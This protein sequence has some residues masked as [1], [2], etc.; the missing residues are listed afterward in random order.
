MH[1]PIHA[2]RHAGELKLYYL[3]EYPLALPM[4]NSTSDATLYSWPSLVTELRTAMTHNIT[5]NPTSNPAP[6]VN[7]TTITENPFARALAEGLQTPTPVSTFRRIRAGARP[8]SV[9]TAVQLFHYWSN[10]GLGEWNTTQIEEMNSQLQALGAMTSETDE[11]LHFDNMTAEQRRQAW[12]ILHGRP[13]QAI[14]APARPR[15]ERV[16]TDSDLLDAWI[17]YPLNPSQNQRLEALGAQSSSSLGW[18]QHFNDLNAEQRRQAMAIIRETEQHTAPTQAHTPSLHA[19][20]EFWRRTEFESGTPHPTTEPVISIGNPTDFHGLKH[21]EVNYNSPEENIWLGYYYTQNGYLV[22]MTLINHGNLTLYMS[23]ELATPEEREILRGVVTPGTG[24]RTEIYTDYHEFTRKQEELEAE[25]GVG[26]NIHESHPVHLTGELPSP[27]LQRM[28][29]MAYSPTAHEVTQ[30]YIH[31]EIPA[32]IRTQLRNNL[33]DVGAASEHDVERW[34]PDQRRIAWDIMHRTPTTPEP[35]P[36]PVPS[37]AEV[38]HWYYLH[39]I[40]SSG[41]NDAQAAEL[42]ALGFSVVGGSNHRHYLQTTIMDMSP[43]ELQQV[44]AVFHNQFTQPENE[45]P[46]PNPTAEAVLD[47]YGRSPP[48]TDEQMD[49]LENS[50]IEVDRRRREL[51]S[52]IREMTPTQLADTWRILH[53]VPTLGLYQEQTNSM[54]EYT[55]RPAGTAPRYLPTQSDLAQWL[56]DNV[57]SEEQK[58]KIRRIF[59]NINLTYDNTALIT[60]L[61]GINPAL[62]LTEHQRKKL[63]EIFTTLPVKDPN[64]YVPML[65]E[66]K[67]FYKVHPYSRLPS[68][69]KS[70]INDARYYSSYDSGPIQRMR[71]WAILNGRPV[72]TPYSH[73]Y[74]ASHKNPTDGELRNIT[75]DKFIPQEKHRALEAAGLVPNPDIGELTE[76]DKKRYWA[77]LNDLRIPQRRINPRE[78]AQLQHELEQIPYAVPEPTEREKRDNPFLIS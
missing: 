29:D 62:Q 16:P 31:N 63:W 69:M 28:R 20:E 6:S 13:A 12:E 50:D 30:Y 26:F 59:R 4:L 39:N 78:L 51:N 8:R 44:W 53:L 55:T 61:E 71:E 17:R 74:A 22:G 64:R 72:P 42:E 2:R 24:D 40:M 10:W 41:L 66:L 46:S 34:T 57:L 73:E 21:I 35:L 18:T 7:P 36:P 27:S 49:A 38:L 75:Q 68:S 70:L 58:S 5:F 11:D 37:S 48:L 54:Q 19:L 25:F 33:V 76:F 15:R 47:Y 43:A 45:L 23:R 32:E 3:G 67:H 56:Q 65:T 52:I 14:S 1:L 60:R 9:P 77:I